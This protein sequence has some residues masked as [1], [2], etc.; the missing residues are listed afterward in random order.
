ML[1]T[2]TPGIRAIVSADLTVRF[3][4]A[5][6]LVVGGLTSASP[7]QARGVI[8]NV[9]GVRPDEHRP[10]RAALAIWTTDSEPWA[11]EEASARISL[12]RAYRPCSLPG[13]RTQAPGREQHFIL[14]E[15][16]GLLTQ[17]E[18]I[19]QHGSQR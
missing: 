3:P 15:G 10:G 19:P 4:S 18:N 16:T 1:L 5:E 8:N 12:S 2:T 7:H 17:M 11:G 6:T 13:E 14:R 9:F